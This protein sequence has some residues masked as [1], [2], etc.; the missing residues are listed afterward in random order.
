MNERYK[1]AITIRSFDQKGEAY[2]K[3]SA[4]TDIIFVNT[5]GQ[6]LSETALVE[7]IKDAEGIIAGTESYP[8]GVLQSAPH[9]KVISRVGVGVDNIDLDYARQNGIRVVN[10]PVAPGDAVAEHTLALI[11]SVLKNIPQYYERIHRGEH[12]VLQGSLIAGKTTGIIGLGRIGRKVATLLE[13]CGSVITFYDPWIKDPVPEHWI[14]KDTLDDLLH[15]ADI[16]TLHSSPQEQSAP[17]LDTKAF[18]SCRPGVVLINTARG[19]LIDEP[20]LIHALD[21][22]H[23]ICSWP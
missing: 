4:N 9:L 14:R 18:A 10:T 20:A 11:F 15:D 12:S 13:S 8:A 19:S 2:A 7:I 1:T 5:S 22:G 6:R 3:L 21:Q 16:I 17:L 23:C